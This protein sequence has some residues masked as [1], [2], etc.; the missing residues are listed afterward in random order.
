AIERQILVEKRLASQDLVQNSD[1]SV[2]I[3]DSNERIAIMINEE[4]HIRMQC[5][6][7]GFQLDKAWDMLNRID[8]VIEEKVEYAFHEQLGYLTSCPTNVGTGLRA[9]AM[10]HLPALTITKQ[11]NGILQI[12]SKIGLTARGLYGEGSEALGNIYQISN[13]ITLGPTEEDIINNLTIACQQIIE[14]ERMAR[15]ALLKVNGMQF[16]DA[17][18][19]AYAVLAHARV[20]EL[21]EFMALVSQVRLGVN[22]NIIPDISMEALD[23]LVITGQPGGLLKNAG[24]SL[25][26]EELNILRA[27]I[28]RKQIKEITKVN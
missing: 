25:D 5:V 7:P 1:A 26:D 17:L 22:L 19:R 14:K 27:E 6:L 9:S 18:W 11:I 20:L 15:K 16:E 3:L 13:Q 23:E 21:K 12:I 4:D 10:L 24:K 8:D 28:M 2:L